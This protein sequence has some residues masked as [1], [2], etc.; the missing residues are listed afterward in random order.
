[1][2]WVQTADASGQADAAAADTA[3]D[4]LESTEGQPFFMGLGFVPPHVPFVAPTEFFDMYPLEDIELISN[5]PDDLDDIPPPAKNLRPFLWNQIGHE[6]GEPA[7]FLAGLLR[8]GVVH[9]RP[10]WDACSTRWSG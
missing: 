3:I 1:M 2:Q 4:L 10:A 6:R 5:P 9:G 7:H 8:L